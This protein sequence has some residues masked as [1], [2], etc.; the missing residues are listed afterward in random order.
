MTLTV[1][2]RLGIFEI[3]APLGAGGMGV[4]YRARDTRLGRDVAI[5]TL[6]ATFANA[7]ERLVRFR[8][9]A[10]I[11]A[12]LNHPNIAAIYGLEDAADGVYL[13]LELVE[14]ETLATRLSGGALPWPPALR[15]NLQITAAIEAA[16]ERGI[17]HRDLKPGNVMLTPA[18]VVKVVDFG[19]ATS[20]PVLDRESDAATAGKTTVHGELSV[21][22]MLLG[23]VSYM[24][25]EQAR[26]QQVDRRSD[27]W[28]FGC[29]LFESLTARPPFDG[30]TTADVIARVLESEPQWSALPSGTPGRL[31]DLLRRCLRKDAAVRPRDM[32]DVRLELEEIESKGTSASAD[33]EHSIAVLPFENLGNRDDEYF[34]MA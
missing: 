27:I 9:E 33:M 29:I 30:E 6:T 12:S 17:V 24:S 18:G 3:V 28:S 11:V 14:G 34:S 13:V 32:R 25:P 19:L 5:K 26:G 8:R 1:G 31:R 20:E 22:G 21:P 10:Q 23:T 16:H 15:L 2:S 7:P 4:V